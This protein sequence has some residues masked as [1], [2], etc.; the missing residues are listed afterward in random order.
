M[1]QLLFTTAKAHPNLYSVYDELD[2]LTCSGKRFLD[3][4]G[5]VQKKN[6]AKSKK[7]K[8]KNITINPKGSQQ[9]QHRGHR[10]GFV[11]IGDKVDIV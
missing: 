5:S 4:Q 2:E 1:K 10:F 6:I 8:E 11:A 3:I 7:W 9:K